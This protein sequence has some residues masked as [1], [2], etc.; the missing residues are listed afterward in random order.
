M[1]YYIYNYVDRTKISDKEYV[2]KNLFSNNIGN[3]FFLQAVCNSV[4]GHIVGNP[5]EEGIDAYILPLANMFRGKKNIKEIE[6]L[7]SLLEKSGNK[8]IVITG[9]G[10][11]GKYDYTENYTDEQSDKQAKEFCEYILQH[12]HSIG[13]RGEFTKNY[14]TKIG[15]EENRIDVIG[16]PSV[17]MFGKKFDFRPRKYKIF[18]KD[19]KIAVNFTPYDYREN[20]AIFIYKILK[21]NIN[22]FAMLQ[23]QVEYDM[24]YNGKE[25]NDMRRVHALLPTYRRNPIILRNRAR[26]FLSVGEWIRCLS[27]FDFTIGTR[28][29]GNIIAILAGCPAMV[30]AIDSRT[31]E[32]SEYHHIP[33][34]SADEINEDTSLELLYYRACA[35]MNDFYLHYEDA[36]KTYC[37]FMKKNNIKLKKDWII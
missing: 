4:D 37:D 35:G 10:A 22:S 15:V 21:N 30:I 20:V 8:N 17:R 14:L 32:L 18:N 26:M 6:H 24:L 29:H 1:K 33:Y 23:D 11:Q 31:R 7:Y 25:I 36:L 12:S 9:V 34:I 19:L 28:I 13:V 2:E 3:L 5:Y 16:C 27:T